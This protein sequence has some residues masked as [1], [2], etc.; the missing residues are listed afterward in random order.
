MC[1][2]AGMFAYDPQALPVDRRELLAIR[3]AMTHRGPDGA[4]LWMSPDGRV[5]LVALTGQRAA[6]QGA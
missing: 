6:W 4:G 3:E 5:G 1:G 2:I